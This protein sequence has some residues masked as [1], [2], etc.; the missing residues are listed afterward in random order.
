MICF[1]KKSFLK[2]LLDLPTAYRRKIETLVF[3][4]IPA[5][6][7]IS[8]NLDVKK[9]QGYAGYYR[10]RIGNYRIGCEMRSGNEIIFYRVKN[11]KDI[12]RI[13]P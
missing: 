6:D 10:I 3:E 12:Y 8:E 5:S 7:N 13:F 4:S 9:I 1:Y 11:R 2:D